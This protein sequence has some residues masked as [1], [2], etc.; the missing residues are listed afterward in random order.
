MEQEQAGQ[1]Y[2]CTNSSQGLPEPC[3]LSSPI[4]G[5]SRAVGSV[6]SCCCFSVVFC[7]VVGY[8]QSGG[9]ADVL[10]APGTGLDL[11]V[12]EE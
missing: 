7:F 4:P 6:G 3:W 12:W 9:D 8:L 5:M 10:S 2:S 1:V 11:C